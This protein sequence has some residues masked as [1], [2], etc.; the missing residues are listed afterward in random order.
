MLHQYNMW[1]SVKCLLYKHEDWHVVPR[2]PVEA[3]YDTHHHSG[4]RHGR[5]WGSLA[6]QLA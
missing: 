1:T 5:I 3:R 6:I 4:G 2:T